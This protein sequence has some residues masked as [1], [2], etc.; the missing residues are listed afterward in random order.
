MPMAKEIVFFCL[1]RNSKVHLQLSLPGKGAREPP[2]A[3]TQGLPALQ[4]VL[5]S[6]VPGGSMRRCTSWFA[7]SGYPDSVLPPNPQKKDFIYFLERGEGRGKRE[8][9]IHQL[10]HACPPTGDLAFNTGMCPNWELKGRPCQ[11][12]SNPFSE[13]LVSSFFH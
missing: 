2:T 1:N 3:A 12:T 5:G 10:P 4:S 9:N 8:R 7:G 6:V 13:E 11:R